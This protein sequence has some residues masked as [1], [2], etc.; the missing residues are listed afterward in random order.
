MPPER[1]LKLLLHESAEDL[2][3]VSLAGSV[4]SI[5]AGDDDEAD[6]VCVSLFEH[7]VGLVRAGELQSLECA[8]LLS[9]YLLC[10]GLS[11]C[12]LCG[13]GLGSYRNAG[14]CLADNGGVTILG[15]SPA[16]RK[17]SCQ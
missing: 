6:V 17:I 9:G 3:A 12:A 8:L 4:V 7:D 16:G 14:G 10:Y 2:C 15:C 13:N 11:G 5:A 1:E